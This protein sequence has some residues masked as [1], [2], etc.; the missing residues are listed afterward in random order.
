VTLTATPDARTSTFAGW[1]GGGCTGTG[2]CTV[3]M[4]AAQNVTATFQ[5]IA[6]PRRITVQ[7]T[8]NGLVE[9]DVQPGI[10]CGGACSFPSFV[11]GSTVV[12]TQTPDPNW[13]FSGWGGDGPCTGTGR[14]CTLLMNR[15]Y[16]INATFVFAARPAEQ[17]SSS[18]S[19]VSD[20][21]VPRGRGQVFLGQR[22]WQVEQGE[23]RTTVA[24]AAGEERVQATLLQAGGG[25]LWRFELADGVVEPGTLRVIEGKVQALA[26][27]AVVFRLTG[28]AGERVAFVYRLARH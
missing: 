3:T 16:V 5:L 24:A 14:T 13:F 21:R 17:R 2:T 11:D 4:T 18:L 26:G 9:S 1:S 25:G 22:A 19:W 27:N 20:L 10:V 23:Q 7:R 28:K 8:G 6:T 15:D 12:L